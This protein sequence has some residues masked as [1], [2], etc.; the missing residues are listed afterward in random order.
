[1]DAAGHFPP[2]GLTLTPLIWNPAR[3][4]ERENDPAKDSCTAQRTDGDLCGR[5][6]A[7]LFV[8]RAEGTS[9]ARC[10]A[11]AEALR[12]ALRSYLREGA[13]TEQFLASGRG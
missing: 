8:L 7:V 5:P 12:T 13:W 10:E 4:E 1:M 3:V 6:T 11:H 2:S 9:L